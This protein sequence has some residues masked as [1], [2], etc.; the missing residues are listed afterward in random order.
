MNPNKTCMFSII[1]I[2]YF[3]MYLH[4]YKCIC[5]YI[6]SRI[7]S[8]MLLCFFVLKKHIYLI[9][10]KKHNRTRPFDRNNVPSTFRKKVIPVDGKILDGVSQLGVA[11]Q[12]VLHHFLLVGLARGLKTGIDGFTE[13]LFLGGGNSNI[14]Y[15]HPETLGN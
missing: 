14:F 5:V 10:Q 2:V 6:R 7:Y 8:C 11:P 13:P 3:N 15:F 12:C 1:Y 9:F 4:M